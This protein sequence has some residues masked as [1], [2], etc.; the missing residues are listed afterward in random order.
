MIEIF[1]LGTGSTVPNIERFHPAVAM[2][3]SGEIFL[4]DCGEGCQIRIQQLHL[5]PHKINHIFISHFH[6]DHCFG[7]PGLLYSM[8]MNGRKTPIHIHSGSPETMKIFLEFLEE[9]V[10]YE[11]I[12]EGP[13]YEGEDVFVHAIKTEHSPFSHAFRLEERPKINVNK[14]KLDALGI[15][16]GPHLKQLRTRDMVYKG[17]TYAQAE[18]TKVKPGKS[19]VYTGDTLPMKELVEFAKTADILIHECTYGRDLTDKA[20]ERR[21][22]WAAA[23]AKTAASAAVKKLVLIHFSRRYYSTNELLDEAKEFFDNTIVAE[24]MMC[25]KV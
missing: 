10:P 24:D 11:I 4:F 5:S 19:I 13:E 21:H 17:K 15:P 22:S 9:D 20:R 25:V 12:Y 23:V 6:G 8:G 18:L 2:R 7:L 14:K 1:F 16:D 3:R